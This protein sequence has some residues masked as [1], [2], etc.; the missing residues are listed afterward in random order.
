M[1]LLQGIPQA[2]EEA[3]KTGSADAFSQLGYKLAKLREQVREIVQEQT[4]GSMKAIIK[5]LESNQSLTAEEKSY[6]KMWVVGDAEGYVKMEQT[7]KEWRDEYQRLAGLMATYARK[8]F[9]IQELLD[10]HGLLEDATKVAD[11]LA[12]FLE[13]QERIQKF[14]AA[15]N[16]LSAS[17]SKL[18]A[19]ILKSKLASPDM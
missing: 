16:N 15:I 4:A 11:N 6:V 2:M 19:D 9:G 18:I 17:D 8:P 10:L 1:D 3:Q 12:H 7:W 14:D 13:D 5:K